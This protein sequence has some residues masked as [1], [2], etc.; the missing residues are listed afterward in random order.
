M[1]RLTPAQLDGKLQFMRDYI[2]AHNAADGSTMD[3]NA[4]VTQKN[5]ATMENELLKDK[6]VRS[7]RRMMPF[8][9]TS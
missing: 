6:T 1:I 3:A 9:S 2:A 5:I 7:G 8:P 4:N